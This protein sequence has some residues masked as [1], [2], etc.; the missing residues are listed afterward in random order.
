MGQYEIYRTILEQTEP[1]W[2]LYLAVPVVVY[3][4]LLTER[5][6]Q[7]IVTKLGLR[8]IVFDDEQKR[9]VLWIE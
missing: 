6:G 5:F 4:S 1:E 3:E 9:V 8:L 7:L 2:R